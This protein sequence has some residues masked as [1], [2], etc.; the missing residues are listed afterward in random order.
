MS[1]MQQSMYLQ[2]LSDPMSL[3]A[4]LIIPF[5]DRGYSHLPDKATAYH[6]SFSANCTDGHYAVLLVIRP[7]AFEASTLHAFHGGKRLNL[8][9]RAISPEPLQTIRG[10]LAARTHCKAD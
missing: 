6:W 3:E 1:R 5:I 7:T 9:M 10:L 4:H 8:I 2:H